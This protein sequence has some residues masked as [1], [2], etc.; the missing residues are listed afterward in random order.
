[1]GRALMYNPATGKGSAF[2]SVDNE[3]KKM[4]VTNLLWTRLCLPLILQNLV[5]RS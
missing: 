2:S 3:S 1:M 5:C 4:E